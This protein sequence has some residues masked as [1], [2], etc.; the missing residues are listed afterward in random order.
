MWEQELMQVWPRY[1]PRPHAV[2]SGDIFSP[3]GITSPVD[4]SSLK[5]HLF[6]RA[7]SVQNKFKV[8]KFIWILFFEQR[9]R[10]RAFTQRLLCPMSYLYLA[11][12]KKTKSVL[13]S[14]AESTQQGAPPILTPYSITGLILGRMM[15]I[16]LV[17]GWVFIKGKYQERTYGS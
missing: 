16:K 1:T 3:R 6:Y 15:K 17:S 8:P 11:H 7:K 5:Q 4:I 13:V 9:E 10:W 2:L 12:Q 14:P